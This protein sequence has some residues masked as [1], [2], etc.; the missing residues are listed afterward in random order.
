[1]NRPDNSPFIQKSRIPQESLIYN[2]EAVGPL[3]RELHR[4]QHVIL[5][6]RLGA[7]QAGQ[8]AAFQ[9]VNGAGTFSQD[10]MAE[11][12]RQPVPVEIEV[13]RNT[14]RLPSRMRTQNGISR[15]R[16]SDGYK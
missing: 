15:H 10:R 2:V 1:M 14:I 16:K 3:A 13:L 11:D 12:R 6:P 9:P 4:T 7:G 8:E 5:P